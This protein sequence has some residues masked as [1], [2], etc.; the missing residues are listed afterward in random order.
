M[1]NQKWINAVLKTLNDHEKHVLGLDCMT[2]LYA[3]R[4]LAVTNY[5]EAEICSI[6][7]NAEAAKID[8]ANRKPETAEEKAAREA[9]NAAQK[10]TELEAA[11]KGA[12]HL[13]ANGELPGKENREKR[14]ARVAELLA[15]PAW[16]A[17]QTER[18][19]K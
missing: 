9:R 4:L 17:A 11:L 16:V 10:K 5:D 12:A 18:L 7:F 3:D 14:A 8:A 19:A 2:G 15:T 13:R 1:K 6:S